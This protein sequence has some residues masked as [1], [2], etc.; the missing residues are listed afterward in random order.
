[1]NAKVN[2]LMELSLTSTI[3][4]ELQRGAAD[5]K[6]DHYF[7]LVSLILSHSTSRCCHCR[8][9]RSIHRLLLRRD[10]GL[11]RIRSQI[12]S[13]ETARL[14]VVDTLFNSVVEGILKTHTIS[15]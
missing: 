8:S 11:D 5:M 4:E 9:T 14:V 7:E 6:L 10:N 3:L 15:P 1:M 2:T 13:I 12:I